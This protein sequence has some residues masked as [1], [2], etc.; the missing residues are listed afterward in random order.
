[1]WIV[2]KNETAFCAFQ[3]WEASAGKSEVIIFLFD[4]EEKV[5]CQF[6]EVETLNIHS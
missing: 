3:Q 4:K 1:M 6:R 2:L 5:W